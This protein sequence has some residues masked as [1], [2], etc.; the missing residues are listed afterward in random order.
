MDTGAQGR[1][2]GQ[3]APACVAFG[4]G[5]GRG[6]AGSEGTTEADE[7]GP[8]RGPWACPAPQLHAHSRAGHTLVHTCDVPGCLSF[9]PAHLEAGGVPSARGRAVKCTRPARLG[10]RGRWRARQSP[11]LS[12]LGDAERASP[13]PL[14]GV[15]GRSAAR[16]GPGTGSPRVRLER[17]VAGRPRR[18]SEASPSQG[19]VSTGR[20][21]SEA[22]GTGGSSHGTGAPALLSWER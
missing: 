12:P 6:R 14:L 10:Q 11:R 4:G 5:E 3:A 20:F 18:W 16:C 17:L 13:T 21:S 2:E 19:T 22:A 7:A 8:Q 15:S 1:A 9:G